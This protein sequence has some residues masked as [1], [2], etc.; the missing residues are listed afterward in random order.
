MG[1][2]L[3]LPFLAGFLLFYIIPFG[4]SVWYS[5]TSGIGGLNFVGIQNYIKVFQSHAFQMAAANTFRF[6]GIGI[7]L[8]M[9][10]SLGLSLLVFQNAGGS[11]L[12]QSVFLYPMV[13]PIGSTVLFFQV[14]LSE[15][16][17]VNRFFA[18]LHLQVQQWLDSGKT[19]YVLLFL[20]IWKNCGYN[21]VLF[22]TGLNNIPKECKEAASI[23]GAGA[24]QYFRYIQCPL[25]TPSFLFVFVMSV[26][27][28]FK[29]YREAY[30]LSGKYP[31]DSIYMLQHFMNNN[32]ESLNYQRLSVAAIL[33]FFV[34]FL[35]V[36]A[37]FAWKA[38]MERED[39][40]K[41]KRQGR[42][43]RA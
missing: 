38:W 41:R 40:G 10:I 1:I 16:G 7:P 42:R 43:G 29:C 30:L 11:R 3:V 20:Y 33:V 37:L 28:S 22:L 25:L 17:A 19:F 31:N 23:E 9:M 12:F 4:I 14:M 26:I 21:M 24:W 18:L 13:I 15:F 34:I 32:F 39:T 2:L 8:V 35:L 27:N 5:F 6:M 36:I